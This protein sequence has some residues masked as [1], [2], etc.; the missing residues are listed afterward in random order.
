M[1]RSIQS[2]SR[3]N[4]AKNQDPGGFPITRG[5]SSVVARGGG[6]CFNQLK[7]WQIRFDGDPG[8][9]FGAKGQKTIILW[10]LHDILPSLANHL[11]NHLEVFSWSTYIYIHNYNIY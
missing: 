6:I 10:I 7:P 5:A 9:R 3:I 4:P 8:V 2:F 1:I 11:K